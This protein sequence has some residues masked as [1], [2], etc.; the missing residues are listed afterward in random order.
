[1]CFLT[2][3]NLLMEKFGKDYNDIH[4]HLFN[5]FTQKKECKHKMQFR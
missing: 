5:Q 1:M 2:S 4:L 3:E